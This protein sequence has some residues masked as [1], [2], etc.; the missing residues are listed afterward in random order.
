MPSHKIHKRAVSVYLPPDTYATFERFSDILNRPMS[1]VIR[2]ALV[3]IEPSLNQSLVIMGTLEQRLRDTFHLKAEDELPA[4]ALHAID[5]MVHEMAEHAKA[6]IDKFLVPAP[7][8]F[9]AGQV[10][11]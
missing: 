10:P 4:A 11:E 2:E 5:Q 8:Q 7:I 9:S 1:R 3:N 6:Q